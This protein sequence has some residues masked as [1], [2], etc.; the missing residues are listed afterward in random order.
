MNTE[1]KEALLHFEALKRELGKVIVGQERT[2]EETLIALFSSGHLLLEGA[3][4]LAKTLLIS[5]LAKAAD[6]KF[7]RIQFT[8]DLLPSDIVGT[9]IFN[10]KTASFETKKGPVFTNFLLADEVNR[11]PPKTQSA[12]LE[13]MQEKQVSILGET[14]V[15]ASPFL[16]MATQ[17]PLEQEGTYPLPEAQMDRF[18]FK[19]LLDY[20]KKD[21]EVAILERFTKNDVIEVERVIDA[22]TILSLQKL[23]RE[24]YIDSL[25][26]EYIA[27]LVDA[28]RYPEK[29]QLLDASKYLKWGASPRAT[30]NLA[31]AAKTYS[32][33]QGRDHVLP[34]DVK[35]L[36]PSVL[37]HRIVLSFE[38]DI[39]KVSA[40]DIIAEILDSIDSP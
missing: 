17:N 29:Y 3:P 14:H 1:Q 31:L 36:A 21:E 40:D 22:Q 26:M 37:R 30:I 8:P 4:G 7:S 24:Q 35:L 34:D 13:A 23:C 9:Q 11:A 25:L 5:T 6:L 39:D 33:M 12:L 27:T 20:P 15:L 28:T 19:V 32:L 2:I 10:Q 16:V 18:M 38:A